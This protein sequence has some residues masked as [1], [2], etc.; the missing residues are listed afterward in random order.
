MPTIADDG[1]L[2]GPV[3]GASRRRELGGPTKPVSQSA[4]CQPNAGRL[5]GRKDHY[6][7]ARI[8]PGC[9]LPST[10]NGPA[11]GRSN[12]KPFEGYNTL[13]IN[14]AGRT[15]QTE[16]VGIFGA[17]A[18]PFVACPG[19][20]IRADK[21]HRSRG[22]GSYPCSDSQRRARVQAGW[23]ERFTGSGKPYAGADSG[24][25]VR[26]SP[27]PHSNTLSPP[28]V[29]RSLVHRPRL[30]ARAAHWRCPLTCT[31]RDRSE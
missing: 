14:V 29:S 31:L 23:L 25:G 21:R 22:G 27:N 4:R 8:D 5:I 3:I 12:C 17:S 16:S 11:P 26:S 30:A 19:A 10:D 2:Q 28:A 20:F 18:Q 13:E 15:A 6:S 7:T 1:E 24:R 9:T